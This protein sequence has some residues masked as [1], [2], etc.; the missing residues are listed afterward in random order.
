MLAM[1]DKYGHVQA[2][3]PG[4]ADRAR[5]TIEKT[6]DALRTLSAPDEWSR[7]KENEGRRIEEIGGGWNLLNYVKYRRIRDEE[8]RKEYMR[9]YMRKRR[10]KQGVNN[11]SNVNSS[12]PRLA[13]MLAQA[14]TDTEVYSE[15]IS[16]SSSSQ[17]PDDDVEKVLTIFKTLPITT[18]KTNQK[19]RDTARTL[20]RSY[21]I[22]Q[23]EGGLLLASARGNGIRKIQSLKYFIGAVA[24][25]AVDP[26]M[27]A[28]Y[29]DYLRSKVR[30]MQ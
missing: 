16:T 1:A 19:D 12:K 17:K 21:S 27:S 23:I 8:E 26:N 6:V 24:E 25:A 3:V 15:H 13:D 11:V 9:Q 5:V 2:S 14:D 29:V 10:G 7:S 18:G 30:K 20:L 4:L 28:T 22:E